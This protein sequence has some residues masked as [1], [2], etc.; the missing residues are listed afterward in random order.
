MATNPRLVA[1]LTAPPREEELRALPAAVGSLE[2]RADL[3]GDL[4]PD[5]LRSFFPGELIYTLRSRHEGGNFEGNKTSRRRRLLTAVA[6]FDLIDLE[7]ERDLQPELLSEIPAGQ[8]LI[9]WHGPA[10]TLNDLQ[11][12]FE[13]LTFHEA[14]FY[15]MIPHAAQAGDELRGLDLLQSLGRSDVVCFS[16][17]EIGTWT[18]V[19][20]P[21]FGSPLIFGSFGEQ[22][23]APGQLSIKKLIEDYGL[24]HLPQVDALFGIVGRPVSHSLSPR[25][26]NSAYRALGLPCLYLPFHAE[27]FADFWLEI[28]ESGNLASLGL[29][30]RGLSVTSPF[31]EVALAVSG[32]SSP[33]AQHIEA[34]NTLIRRD[35][36]WEAE[37]TDPEGIVLALERQGRAIRGKKAAIVGCGGAGKA[38]AYALQLAGAGVTLINRG[39]ERGERASAA[40]GLPFQSLA[41]F[42]PGRFDIIVQATD[43]GRAAGDPLPF[44]PNQLRA[45]AVVLDMVYGGAP[46]RFIEAV[47]S[48]GRQAIDGREILLFQALGQFRLM[49]GRALDESLGRRLL[50]MERA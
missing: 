21:R 39:H 33:R 43:L 2:L 15:K 11:A 46:T 19:I 34:A 44:D 40:L 23:A 37:T 45:E 48:A 14:K 24:P 32:A 30:L 3:C 7:A 47:R 31:K 27:S 20:A 29:D 12:R 26:H 25:L 17:G 50:G 42:D 16:T 1:T 41:D 49:T 8:R 4:D 10:A 5:W 28:V 18:R 36:V 38:A 9:S 6:G 35:E 13:Q 22:A